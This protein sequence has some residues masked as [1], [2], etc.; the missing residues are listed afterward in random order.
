MLLL[1]LYHHIN[2]VN[3][4]IVMIMYVYS[5]CIHNW[6]ICVLKYSYI[7]CTILITIDI[8]VNRCIIYYIRFTFVV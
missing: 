4:N 2:N 8:C 7:V 5:L 6:Y 3:N 1:L